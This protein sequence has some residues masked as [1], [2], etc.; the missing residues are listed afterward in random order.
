MN[1]EGNNDASRQVRTASPLCTRDFQ[2]TVDELPSAIPPNWLRSGLLA[3]CALAG[4][5]TLG[6]L[7]SPM[8]EFVTAPGVVRPSDFTLVF[9]RVGGILSDVNVTDGMWVEEKAVL[10]RFDDW[11]IQKQIAQITGEIE[12]AQA[13]LDIARA[14][15]RK[16]EAAPVPPEFLF[17]GL[18]ME[19]QKEVQDIQKDY[20]K[21]L[22]NL[23]KT[24][25]ASGTELL[26]IRLQMIASESLLKRSQQANELFTGGYG[27]AAK[28]ES[29]AR[30][31]MIESR[32]KSLQ[33]SLADANEDL[34]RL[35]VVA[36]ESGTILATARRY[37]G[38]K[39]NAGDALFK[40]T[41]NSESELRLYA[42]QDRVNLIAPG[43]LVRFRSNNNPDRLAPLAT[44][45]VTAVASDRD[46]EAD[47]DAGGTASAY[48]V[49]VAIEKAPY[50]LA[51]GA[52][53][54]AEI[55]IARRPFWRLLL[56]KSTDTM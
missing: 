22:Q 12:Q 47:P 51:V 5:V 44:G 38:E 8:D 34:R 55:I 14:S 40:V 26:S 23:Q 17:S 15:V 43:Q 11:E 31:R 50:E 9:S 2:K 20:Y 30:E 28:D 52:T 45:R 42:S 19:S 56:M 16:I 29:T 25:A 36:P 13:E 7:T 3:T 1:P 6:V 49:S 46:L 54:E 27:D 10:A 53:V 24:G 33:R 35:E 48:R 18:E 39:V 21:R 41:K 32:L 37:P 4:I